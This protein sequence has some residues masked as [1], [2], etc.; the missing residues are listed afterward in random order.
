MPNPN[1]QQ[2]AVLTLEAAILMVIFALSAIAF[3]MFLT[4][5]LP[6]LFSAFLQQILQA[7]ARMRP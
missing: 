5:A 2:G 3:G 4:N 1:K 6:Q 7:I